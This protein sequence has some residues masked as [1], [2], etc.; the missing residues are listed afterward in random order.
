MKE[1]TKI[2]KENK[3]DIKRYIFT[4]IKQIEIKD[5][6]NDLTDELFKTF[7]SLKGVYIVDN[8]FTQITPL[9]TR[10][11]ID[12]TRI[13]TVRKTLSENIKP[14]SEDEYISSAYISSLDGNP[15]ITA[16]KRISDDKIMT[17]DFNLSK[18]LSDLKYINNENFF[19]FMSKFIY[20][21]IGYSLSLFS[22]VLILYAIYNFIHHSYVGDIAIFE[23]IFKSIIALTLGLAVFDLAKNL[24]EHEVVY[25]ERF[26]ESHGTN[27]LLE[28][29]LISIIIALSI[30]ALMTVFKIALT[31]YKD[32]LY[33][34]YLIVAVSIMIISLSLFNKNNKNAT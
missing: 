16:T 34:V 13:N 8:N 18:L 12:K 24:L 30:E 14:N 4:V 1:L 31:D 22:L 3:L 2:F 29:F 17:F 10:T 33:A 32:I 23:L 7:S 6:N 27:Q 19:N 25:K 26:S 5:L 21:S 15:T 9:C 11:K 28:K 20:G